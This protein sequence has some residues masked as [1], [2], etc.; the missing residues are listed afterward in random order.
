M[1]RVSSLRPARDL[2]A[3]RYARRLTEV[4]RLR[5]A[6]GEDATRTPLIV[7]EAGKGKRLTRE[8]RIS[9][10][11]EA[12]TFAKEWEGDRLLV[13]ATRIARFWGTWLALSKR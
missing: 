9:P 6:H 1:Q 7:M 10:E 13:G 8:R 11:I 12:T 3:A 5:P 4:V 2:R